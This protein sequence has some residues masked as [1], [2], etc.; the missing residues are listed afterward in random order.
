MNGKLKPPSMSHGLFNRV[1]IVSFRG[2]IK[3]E[4]NFTAS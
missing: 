1:L 3:I 4:I 2:F